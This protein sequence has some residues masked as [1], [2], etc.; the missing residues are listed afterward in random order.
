MFIIYLDEF[1]EVA[2]NGSFWKGYLRTGFRPIGSSALNRFA[3]SDL[4][5]GLSIPRS[6]ITWRPSGFFSH[7]IL[8]RFRG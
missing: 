1:P 7:D 2:D 6:F 8:M 3:Y 4:H 5:A